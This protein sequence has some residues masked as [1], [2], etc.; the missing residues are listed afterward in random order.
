M[1]RL[2]ITSEPYTKDCGT[3]KTKFVKCKCKCGNLIEVRLQSVKDSNTKS[4]GCLNIETRNKLKG[5]TTHGLS[6]HPLYSL[7]QDIK[8][9]CY[10]KKVNNYNDYGGR[11][12]IVCKEWKNDFVVF[13]NWAINNGWGKGLEI[14]RKNNNGNYEP[15]N[16]RFGSSKANSNNRRSN[17]FIKAFNEEKTI[18]QW[19]DDT[20]CSIKYKTLWRRINM[21]WNVER[22]I[23]TPKYGQKQGDEYGS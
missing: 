15:G 11:G 22:A 19:I 8:N 9:R 20:R 4:C 17:I 12:I 1:N 2:T 10:N 16:C 3:Y 21:G 6:K 13:Y 23:T 18:S 14:D 5:I 7:W